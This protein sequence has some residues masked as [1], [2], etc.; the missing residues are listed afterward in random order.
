MAW[1]TMNPRGVRSLMHT[2]YDRYAAGVDMYPHYRF[3]GE[4]GDYPRK[5]QPIA[6]L[7]F[8]AWSVIDE[9]RAYFGDA[10]DTCMRILGGVE[11]DDAGGRFVITKVGRNAVRFASIDPG[12]PPRITHGEFRR[13]EFLPILEHLDIGM[14]DGSTLSFRDGKVINAPDAAIVR[15]SNVA[16]I[17]LTGYEPPRQ[18]VGV[19]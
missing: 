13:E 17:Y 2:V 1:P 5:T 14:T 16:G 11:R 19:E 15:Q 9:D 12:T 6:R 4:P 7:I 18:P 10:I 3:K 8:N